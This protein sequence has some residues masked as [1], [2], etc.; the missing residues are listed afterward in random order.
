M[1]ERL[2][3]FL[4]VGDRER[5]SICVFLSASDKEGEGLS[6]SNCKVHLSLSHTHDVSSKELYVLFL[7]PSIG[8]LYFLFLFPFQQWAAHL[9]MFGFIAS[10][11]PDFFTVSLSL[12]TSANTTKN[13][14]TVS[15]HPE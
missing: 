13:S 9:C 6:L 14:Q 4:S 2:G 11:N 1:T 15:N 10:W 12:S 5:K 8:G 3:G 7:C